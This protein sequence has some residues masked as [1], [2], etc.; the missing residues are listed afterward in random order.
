[1]TYAEPSCQQTHGHGSY[2]DDSSLYGAA[3]GGVL[4]EALT[5]HTLFAD[6]F[7]N[8]AQWS[9]IRETMRNNR[10]MVL[11]L[12][13]NT[14]LYCISSRLN[15]RTISDMS[16]NHKYFTQTVLYI[17]DRRL[18]K[19]RRRSQIIAR[20]SPNIAAP[21]RPNHSKKSPFPPSCRLTDRNPVAPAPPAPFPE[22]SRPAS[23]SNA[24]NSMEVNAPTP[25]H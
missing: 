6:A 10:A 16:T 17:I 11:R 25:C 20:L 15:S 22:T 8:F 13:F 1:M 3:V 9:N 7:R 2:H 12:F 14:L 4:L 19:F 23:P 5:Y 24:P 21:F 18:K